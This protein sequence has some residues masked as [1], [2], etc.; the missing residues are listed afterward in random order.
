MYISKEIFAGIGDKKARSKV[1]ILKHLKTKGRRGD[2]VLKIRDAILDGQG[3]QALLNPNKG[4]DGKSVRNYLEQMEKNGLVS[5][6]QEPRKPDRWTLHDSIRNQGAIEIKEESLKD[7]RSLA[8]MLNQYRHIPF[9]HDLENWI[10]ANGGQIDD[11]E[12]EYTSGRSIIGFDAVQ[13]STGEEHIATFY[14][15]IQ[16]KTMLNFEL[17]KYPFGDGRISEIV[18]IKNFRPHLLREHGKRWYVVGNNKPGGKFYCYGLDR[19]KNWLD[20][21]ESDFDPDR[22]DPGILWQYSLGIYTQWKDEQGESHDTPPENGISFRIKNGSRYNNIKYLESSRIHHSQTP[23]VLD[24]FDEDGFVKVNLYMFPDS[25]L[26]RTLRA[27]G[28][29]NL[30]DITPPFLDKWVRED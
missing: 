29:H 18:E 28:T 26:V 11:I 12:Q 2:T 1:L 21:D 6:F 17:E 10:E 9:I 15:S 8:A 20:G 5:C 14:E 16:D 30:K 23:L 19:V 7:L 24:Q 13:N 25:D 4:K 22:F 3:N 27:F